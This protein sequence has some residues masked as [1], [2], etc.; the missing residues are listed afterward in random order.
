MARP[1][2]WGPEVAA[3]DACTA[4][5]GRAWHDDEI[6]TPSGTPR[7]PGGAAGHQGAGQSGGKS[8]VRGQVA[9]IRPPCLLSPPR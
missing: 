6:S 1:A 9:M 7:L 4:A 5:Q 3:M 8:G 2:L